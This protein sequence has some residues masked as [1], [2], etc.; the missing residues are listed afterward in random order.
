MTSDT[1]NNSNSNI[2]LEV[3]QNQRGADGRDATTCNDSVPGTGTGTSTGSGFEDGSHRCSAEACS[4]KKIGKNVFVCEQSNHVHLCDRHHIVHS[5]HVYDAR[6]EAV[7]CKI[8][9]RVFDWIG[10]WHG[11]EDG[12]AT[13]EVGDEV[14]EDYD[15]AQMGD[16]MESKKHWW[17]RAY[18]MG[19]NAE[20]EEDL[21]KITR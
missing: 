11:A 19:Y 15:A 12:A 14:G 10:D 20:N 8:S 5:A 6:Q 21:V 2:Q 16:E 4:I 9:G 3:Q 17:A 18:E 1:A 7:L 13:H